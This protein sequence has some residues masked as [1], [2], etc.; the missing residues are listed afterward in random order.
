MTRVMI[1]K[2]YAVGNVVVNVVDALVRDAMDRGVI[3]VYTNI[4]LYEVV[5]NAE[6]SK[7]M[8]AFNKK[9]V[10]LG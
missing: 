4:R 6:K 7:F 2:E 3:D 1:L 5:R 8:A 9:L 10:A